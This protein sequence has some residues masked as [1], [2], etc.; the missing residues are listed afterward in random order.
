M[1]KLFCGDCINLLHD[2]PDGTVDLIY[3]DP[4]YNSGRDYGAFND[5]WNSMPA[6]IDYLKFRLVLMH[7]ALKKTGSIY[8]HIDPSA[9]HYVKVMADSIFGRGQFR[10]EIIWLYQTGGAGKKA[11]AKKHDTILFYS[12]TNDYVFNLQK[13]KQYYPYEKQ[14]GIKKAGAGDYEFLQDEKGIYKWSFMRDW[15]LINRVHQWSDERNRYPTQK[16][17]ELLKR[18]ISLSSNKN[19][20]VLDAFCGSGTT[21]VAAKQM[22]RQFI[23]MDISKTAIDLS[24]KRLA[25]T[26]NN[27][28]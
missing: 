17:I 28:V 15:W 10:N 4:P 22:N 16:P 1:N 5:K 12:K 20:I 19:D 11:L 14:A 23:G 21:L 13:E 3:I 26:Q 8:I 2:I 25:D 7:K 6:Y 9:S 24:K 18:I 27:L